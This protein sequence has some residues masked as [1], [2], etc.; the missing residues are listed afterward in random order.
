MTVKNYLN[1]MVES[2]Q[3]KEI[4][5]DEITKDCEKQAD[6]LKQDELSFSEYDVLT[7]DKTERAFEISKLDDGFTALYEK[8]QKQLQ[9]NRTEYRT[10][11]LSMQALIK[12][13]AEKI[14][15]IQTMEERNKRGLE[16][17]LRV[18][19]MET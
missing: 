2:L 8:A 1:I 3:K 9:V 17:H 12:V 7:A 6:L 18:Q 15:H 19:G 14:N 5:L 11:I 4:L 13:I 10:L 16:G